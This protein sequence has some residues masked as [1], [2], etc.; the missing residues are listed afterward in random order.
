[1]SMAD[2]ESLPCSQAMVNDPDPVIKRLEDETNE[3]QPLPVLSEAVRSSP[4]ALA[5]NPP[6]FCLGITGNGSVC[7]WEAERTS[8]ACWQKQPSHPSNY[9][10]ATKT[11]RQ[12]AGACVP[13]CRDTN[14]TNAFHGHAHVELWFTC[15]ALPAL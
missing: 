8:L 7:C 11:C 15:L 3:G 1:M 2:H 12:N 5:L 4:R 9:T 14:T 10:P 13:V 6:G